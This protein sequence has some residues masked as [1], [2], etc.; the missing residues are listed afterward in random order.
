MITRGDICWVELG[1]PS[2]SEP[3]YRHPLVVISDDDFNRSRISTVIGAVVTSNLRL[4]DA[5]GNVLLPASESGLSRDS[6]I[7][8]SQLVTVGKEEAS[9]PV[10]AIGS[11]TMERIEDGL[12]LILGLSPPLTRR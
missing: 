8:V 12:R 6:V 10:G 2:G 9:E 3:G 5:P 11:T 4:L 1:E 7:N